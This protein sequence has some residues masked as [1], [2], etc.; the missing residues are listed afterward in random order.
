MLSSSPELCC[1]AGPAVRLLQR[2]SGH[3]D[4][5]A[6]WELCTPF[7][8]QGEGMPD[9]IRG[10]GKRGRRWERKALQFT[11]LLRYCKLPSPLFFCCSPLARKRNFIFC[12]N[13]PNL[14]ILA[15]NGS[16][17]I[18]ILLRKQWFIAWNRSTKCFREIFF[19]KFK[20][21]PFLTSSDLSPPMIKTS[22]VKMK[23]Q[24]L[25]DPFTRALPF[26]LVCTVSR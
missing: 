11:T 25:R 12:K 14:L 17:T 1:K 6:L 21:K 16:V 10:P 19:L 5:P 2:T 23:N 22:T 9:S 7:S 15:Q 13:N 18:G 26:F 8:S 3:C 20:P 4:N 24:Q